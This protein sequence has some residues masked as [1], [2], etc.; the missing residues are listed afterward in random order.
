MIEETHLSA[1][2]TIRKKLIK[3]LGEKQDN[4][5]NNL[6]IKIE[7]KIRIENGVMKQ[8][9]NDLKTKCAIAEVEHDELKIKHETLEISIASIGERLDDEYGKSRKLNKEIDNLKMENEKMHNDAKEYTLE[10]NSL[11]KALTKCK[12]VNSKLENSKKQSEENYLMLENVVANH[13]QTICELENKVIKLSS[14][15]S[16]DECE[17]VLKTKSSSQEQ[18]FRL[19][20]AENIPSTSKCGSCEY[21][22][23]DEKDMSQHITLKHKL[24]CD[25]CDL[26]FKSES[27]LTTHM[28]RVN[29]KNPTCGDYFT[30]KWVVAE[31]C[32]RFFSTPEEREFLILHSKQCFDNESRC[33]D[34]PKHYDNDISNYDGETWHAR[35]EDFF[36]A[37]TISWEDLN[38]DFDIQIRW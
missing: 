1:Y 33:C 29:V 37:G 20:E 38:G 16:C 8:Q 10:I 11:K 2:I 12:E 15:Q 9:I 6:N 34:M 21:E 22:S 3:P 32:M 25:I 17:N 13:V 14:K 36:F 5:P 23:D 26:T 24:S 28:C 4:V 27:R 30:K 7:E 19:H 18:E 31:G 35:L